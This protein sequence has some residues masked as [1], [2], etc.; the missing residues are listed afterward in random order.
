LLDVLVKAGY[1]IGPM[2]VNARHFL[3]Q[4]RP[5]LFIIAVKKH[6]TTFQGLIQNKPAVLWHSGSLRKTYLK[7]PE[8]IRKAWMWIWW[9]LPKPPPYACT[10]KDLIMVLNSERQ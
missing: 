8:Y 2:V 1:R 10:L 4:S 9:H 5:R 3:P 6:N 7:L